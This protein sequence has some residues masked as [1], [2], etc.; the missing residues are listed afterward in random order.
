M[1]ASILVLGPLLAR[2][3]Q[4]DVSLPGG[5]AIGSRPVN[6]H[7]EGLRAMGADI[8]CR[9]RL[10]PRPGGAAARGAPGVGHGHRHRHREPDDG[11]GPGRRR[12]GDRECGPGAG[13]GGPGGVPEQHGRQDHRC[14]HRHASTSRASSVWAATS[15]HVLP[16]RIETGTYLVAAAITGGTYPVP[17][18]APGPARRG[19]GQAARGR[20]RDR[21]RRRL[22]PA[23]HGG[24]TAAGG[25][26]PDRAATRLPHRHAGPVH[27]P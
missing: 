17:G 18:H 14:R 6:L 21:D 5:C 13:G 9:E 27:V 23:G 22:D 8:T 19:A 12:D 7:I 2:F 25:G 11:R 24:Q 16:D 3:G 1:R 15:Y 4:A 20:R 26:H 10:H